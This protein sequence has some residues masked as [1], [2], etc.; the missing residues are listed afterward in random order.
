M[1]IVSVSTASLIP[2]SFNSRKHSD[3]QVN[4]L[5]NSIKEF[6]FRVPILID[7][8]NVIL[9]GHGRLEAAKKLGLQE[10]PTIL[11]SELTVVQKKAYRIIDN[12]LALDSEWDPEA[13]SV[14]FEFLKDADF[15]FSP[16]N[17]SE[18]YQDSLDDSDSE[19]SDKYTKKVTA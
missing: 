17:L 19:A 10:V 4:H 13:L 8:G 2:Y 7:E 6:G 1:N 18:M 14:E 16:F 5:A 9:A 11:V 15:D 12:K 3:Q